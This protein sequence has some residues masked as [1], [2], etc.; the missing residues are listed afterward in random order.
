MFSILAERELSGY[1]ESGSLSDKAIV[2]IGDP[3][4]PIP[5]AL[6]KICPCFLRLEFFDLGE[7]DPARGRERIPELS[8]V[9]ACIEFYRKNDHRD[10]I[11]QSDLGLGRAP[12]VAMGLI[13]LKTGK[14]EAAKNELISLSPRAMP[15]KRLV[16]LFDRVLGTDL[17][18]ANYIIWMKRIENMRKT[19]GSMPSPAV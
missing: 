5:Q 8:D 17:R 7:S 11:I 9:K 10:F 6:D 12:A 19:I 18:T 14:E 4:R 3:G 2:S 16:L 13:Y 15:N 1:L